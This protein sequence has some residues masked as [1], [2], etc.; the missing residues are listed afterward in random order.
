MK[1]LIRNK[2]I[3][4]ILLAIGGS[5]ADALY[6]LFVA[7]SPAALARVGDLSSCVIIGAGSVVMLRE[8]KRRKRGEEPL[9]PVSED[10]GPGA[11][12]PR[13]ES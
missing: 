6:G 2:F 1:W 8:R 12:G 5:M 11:T 9:P 4:L 7:E 3:I 10:G 13:S